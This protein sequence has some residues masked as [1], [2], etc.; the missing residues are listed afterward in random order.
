MKTEPH[1][2][3]FEVFE[4][5]ALKDSLASLYQGQLRYKGKGSRRM[6]CALPSCFRE[7]KDRVLW[8]NASKIYCK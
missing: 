2:C 3:I 5:Y 7:N 8:K 4:I 1:F 6:L